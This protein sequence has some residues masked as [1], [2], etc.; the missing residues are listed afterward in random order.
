MTFIKDKPIQKLG[1]EH[2]P[3]GLWLFD[4]NLNDSSGNGFNLTGTVFGYSDF[5]AILNG[6]ELTYSTVPNALQIAG[7][8]TIE[9]IGTIVIG[10]GLAIISMSGTGE[11]LATNCLYQWTM[12]ATG[13]SSIFWEYGVGATNV[14]W[15][16]TGIGTFGYPCY[17]AL[18]RTNSEPTT[19]TV[20]INGEQIGNTESVHT[21]EGGTSGILR[22]FAANDGTFDVHKGSQI[23]CLKILNTCLT[24]DEI[25]AEYNRTLGGRVISWPRLL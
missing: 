6:T 5:G 16:G 23:S 19:V 2:S 22:A 13:T 12:D 4:G 7:A 3:V 20:Y 21:A 15:T 25:K 18:T 17:M 9:L 1:L 10:A 8:L 14:T 11:S 24:P